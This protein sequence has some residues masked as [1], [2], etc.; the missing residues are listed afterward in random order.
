MKGKDKKPLPVKGPKV[1]LYD[2]SKDIG[3]RTN[4]AEQHPEVVAP[5]GHR[6]SAVYRGLEE[7]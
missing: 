4:V 3:E 6:L 1:Q 5:S 2:L 7:E